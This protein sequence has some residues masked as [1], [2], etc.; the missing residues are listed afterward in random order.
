MLSGTTFC[1]RPVGAAYY[2]PPTK[3]CL[4]SSSLLGGTVCVVCHAYESTL[5]SL[6]RLAVMQEMMRSI[7]LAAPCMLLQRS[8][9]FCYCA[10]AAACAQC[11]QPA[12]GAHGCRGP[13]APDCRHARL[14]G[15]ACALQPYMHSASA[16]SLPRKSC[17]R[18][19]SFRIC[20]W[21]L[22]LF[23]VRWYFFLIPWRSSYI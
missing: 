21:P 13:R 8:M 18:I 9:R 11:P 14:A 4:S 6:S 19:S 16:W 15:A 10:G 2:A 7:G 23:Y 22:A 17:A 20:E 12:R 5:A 3:H 1:G